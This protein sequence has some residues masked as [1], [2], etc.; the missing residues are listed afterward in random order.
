MNILGKN[1]VESS[2][3]I[4]TR[5]GSQRFGMSK[6]VQQTVYEKQRNS[7]AFSFA[8]STQLYCY[9]IASIRYHYSRSL[10]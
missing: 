3:L 9:S 2:N 6:N 8:F 1:L 10:R 7:D 5:I 4:F